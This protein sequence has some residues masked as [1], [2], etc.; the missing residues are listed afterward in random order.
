MKIIDF[1][2]KGNVVR[3]YC[4]KDDCEDYWGDDWNDRP[5]DR[6]YDHKAER[7]Y[8]EYVEEYIDVAVDMNYHV[9]EPADDWRC[10]E[11][12]PFS[13]EDMKK[14][15][16]PCIIVVPEDDSYVSEEFNRYA[17]S[18]NVDKIY[19]GDSIEKLNKYTILKRGKL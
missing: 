18:D 14:R 8:S 15:S 6:Y 11:N 1:E 13:K 12:T 17:V 3:F 4:G 2:K 9:M 19:F 7:V 5:Y 16:V 10:N